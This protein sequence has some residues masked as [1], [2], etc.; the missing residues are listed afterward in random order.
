MELPSDAGIVRPMVNRRLVAFHVLACGVASHPVARATSRMLRIGILEGM[1]Q[2]VFPGRFEAFKDGLRRAGYGEG[3]ELQFVYRTA[4]GHLGEL[5]A[6]AAEL[7]SLN[8]DLIFAATTAAAVAARDA[9]KAIP[10]VFAVVA[11]PIGAK[12]VASL[13]QPGGNATGTTT[14]NTDIAA[15]RLQLLGELLSGR[16]SR[17]AVLFNPH[18][19]SNVIGARL[20]RDAGRTLRIDVTPVEVRS[21]D[22]LERAFV[23]LARETV[24]GVVVAAGPLTD[25]HGRRIAELAAQARIPTMYGAPEFVEAGGL[26]SYSA[27]FSDNYRRAAAYVDRIL[28][29]AKPRE[30]PVEQSNA[31]ELVINR[32]TAAAL[33]LSIPA[34]LLMRARVID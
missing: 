25:S 1:P 26:L 34:S 18:D 2:A 7:V 15:K 13:A 32:R 30:L 14:G 17:V 5:P 22:D 20:I 16:A 4:N 33:G 11:D 23:R 8:V 19:P 3:Q 28:R 10:I 21:L 27:S 12:L 9:T 6:L 31:L 29:G 24:D